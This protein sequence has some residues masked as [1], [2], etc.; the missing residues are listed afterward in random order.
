MLREF[1]DQ[2]PLATLSRQNLALLG[3]SAATASASINSLTVNL[4]QRR[5]LEKA[6][7]MAEQKRLDQWKQV[8]DGKAD[9]DSYRDTE[10][11]ILALKRQLAALDSASP[12]PELTPQPATTSEAEELNRIR[13]LV[14]DSPDLINAPV[15]TPEGKSQTLLQTAAAKGSVA[16]VKLLLDSG[17]AI[18]GVKQLD[19]TGLHFAAANGHKAV[20]ELLLQRGANVGAIS[21]K[22]VTPLHLAA[23]KGYEAV[24][25][26]LLA[27]GAP[28][29]IRGQL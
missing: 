16:T 1:S 25:G 2:T 7:K 20:V 12:S 3:G 19:W 21:D 24:V 10:Q 8:A 11:E 26:S 17:A 15:N 27:A 29:N 28:V 4:E 18:E 13:A 6:L 22:G 9:A 23:L 14:K 5:R